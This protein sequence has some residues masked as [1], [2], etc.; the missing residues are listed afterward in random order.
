[1]CF[2][3][4]DSQRGLIML[5]N[6]WQLMRQIYISI[7]RLRRFAKFVI[8]GG[9]A[10]AIGLLTL[11]AI[12]NLLNIHYLIG[13][14]GAFITA[15]SAGYIANWLWTFKE[16]GKRLAHQRLSYPMYFLLYGLNLVVIQAVSS[17]LV[18]VFGVYYI[19]ATLCG[20]LILVPINYLI[21][22]NWIFKTL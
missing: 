12:V 1:M 18:E 4:S 11:W 10:G 16:R 15:T 21:N 13:N 2:L 5:F 19:L 3:S 9:S 22:K 6:N 7:S 8:V 14:I 20:S 17:L